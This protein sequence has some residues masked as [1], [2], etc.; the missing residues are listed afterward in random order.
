MIPKNLT[1]QHILK[2]IARIERQGVPKGR[3]S[4]KYHLLHNGRHFPPKYVISLANK[5]AHGKE[6]SP[7]QF[8]GG[9]QSN[10][11]LLRLGF[12][13]IGP[14]E[15][16]KV[17]I[18][19]KD[20]A[21]RG[22]NERCSDCKN[23]IIEMLRKAFG[24]VKIDPK[25]ETP[26]RLED[27]KG[28]P[29]FDALRKIFS[30]L[31][32]Y[33]GHKDFVRLKTLPRCDLYVPHPGF[34]VELDESQHFTGAR[35]LALKNYPPSLPL[36]FDRH[37][38]MKLC[39]TIDSKDNNPAYRDEQRAWYDTL[40]D[41]LPMINGLGCTV[42][43]NMGEMQWCSL[44]PNNTKDFQLFMTKI[45]PPSIETKSTIRSHNRKTL[46]A[47]IVIQSD[48]NYT[49]QNRT[50]LLEAIVTKLPGKVD[51]VLCPAGFYQTPR[52]ASSLYTFAEKKIKRILYAS[53]H[54]CIVCLGIDGRG[55]KDQMGL[56]INS[57]GILAVGR[58][59]HPTTQEAS[60]TEVATSEFATEQGF[61]RT[62]QHKGKRFFLA[63]CYDAFGI[64]Q[65]RLSNPGVEVVLDL[66]HGVYP[67]G[68]RGSGDVYFAKHGFA[69]SSKQW[70]CPTFGAAVFF[71]RHIPNNWPTGVLWNQG[72]RS[73]Q[74][75]RYE[76]NALLPSESFDVQ[77]GF[78]L[79]RVRIF[80]V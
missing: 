8:S 65:R 21:A 60:S 22:H 38:W 50:R 57:K 24:N 29:S 42:R 19:R 1:R 55:G 9:D 34:V 47:T 13:I 4:T 69:G 2:A 45:P 63:V 35:C 7:E 5:F 79:A 80:D 76:D 11:F 37:H 41:F 32:R 16:R 71:N 6:L 27:Y 18:N 43:L 72:N 59:F 66:V 17:T 78:E 25:V 48:G 12:Q 54:N 46:V 3:R 20:A 26:A 53:S 67:Q 70:N 39:R 14:N 40:R 61:R 15:D 49:N 23:V 64:R 73:T 44:N 36:G 74:V 75:W 51:V 68:N 10:R 77:R 28:R 33:R 31:V 62:F 52:R 56:A 30:V 58:K